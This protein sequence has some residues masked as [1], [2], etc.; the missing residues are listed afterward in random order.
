M[1]HHITAMLDVHPQAAESAETTK[2][3]GCIAACF[4]CAPDLHSLR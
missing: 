2:L 4:Q 1:T 3:A